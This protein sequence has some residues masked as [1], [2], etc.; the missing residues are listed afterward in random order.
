MKSVLEFSRFKQERQPITMVTCYDAWSAKLIAQAPL[1]AVLVG[2]SAAMVMHGHESTVHAH[3][4]LMVAHTEAAARGLAGRVFLVADLPFPLH[5]LGKTR[6]LEAA[7]RLMKAGAQAVKLEGF[8]GHED[9]VSHLVESGVPVMGH[10]GLTPQSVHQMGG[11]RVQAR[12]EAAAAQ[13][14]ED[15]RGLEAAGAFAI[16]LECIPSALAGR[17]TAA[18]GIPTIGIGSGA[19][20]DGQILVLQDLLGFNED[21][22]PK[23]VRTYLD[24]ASLVKDALR[25]YAEDTK[26]AAFPARE[27]SFS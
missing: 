19:A 5:R 13:L 23:F 9:V 24:G 2:D 27:E 17:V 18:L 1:D 15:A 10:L 7:D 21:F 12:E 6:A 16:V 11:Y 22:R 3:L 4:D 14:L 8:R 25:R 20:C 26:T